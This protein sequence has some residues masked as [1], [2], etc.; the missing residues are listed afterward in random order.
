M[1]THWLKTYFLGCTPM[2]CNSSYPD[3]EVSI[4]ITGAD[5]EGVISPWRDAGGLDL[6]DVRRDR[7][8][9]GDAHV[10]MDDGER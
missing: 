8:L 3:V 4:F 1:E 6:E 9:R 2:S 10:A 7:A 5:A